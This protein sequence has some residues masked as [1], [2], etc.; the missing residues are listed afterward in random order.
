MV[1]GVQKKVTTD[2]GNLLWKACTIVFPSPRTAQFY[3]SMKRAAKL[4]E[5]GKLKVDSFWTRAYNRN[6]EWQKA[7][8]DGLNR[9]NNYGRGYIVW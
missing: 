9:S 3:D 5:S 8:S 1:F 6:T 7:F 2:F 4:I